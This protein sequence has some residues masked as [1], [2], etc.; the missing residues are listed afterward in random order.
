VEALGNCPV[1]LPPLK[2]GPGLQLNAV[3]RFICYSRYVFIVRRDS[4]QT[5]E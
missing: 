2:S 4:V 5:S 1:S 3:A